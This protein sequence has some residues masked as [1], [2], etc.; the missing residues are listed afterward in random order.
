MPTAKPVD[1]PNALARR[2][3]SLNSKTIRKT[4]RTIIAIP[5]RIVSASITKNRIMPDPFMSLSAE[6]TP[7]KMQ[8]NIK[9]AQKTDNTNTHAERMT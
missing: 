4:M 5:D 2:L 1:F 9:T 8:M 7:A 3:N 6:I